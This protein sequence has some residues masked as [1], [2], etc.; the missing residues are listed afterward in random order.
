MWHSINNIYH[1]NWHFN[2]IPNFEKTSFL[3][4]RVALLLH[5]VIFLDKSPIAIIVKLIITC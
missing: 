5:S 1:K 2:Q 4:V 3:N